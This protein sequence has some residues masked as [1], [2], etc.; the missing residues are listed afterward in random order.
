MMNL[1]ALLLGVSF[2]ATLSLSPMTAANEESPLGFADN[3]TQA[4][5]SVPRTLGLTLDRYYSPAVGS[6]LVLSLLHSVQTL[7]DRWLSANQNDTSLQPVLSRIG[8]FAIEGLLWNTATTAQHEI[9]GHGFRAREFHIPAH[10][11]VNIGGGGRIRFPAANYHQL[12]SHEKAAFNAGGMEGNSRLAKNLRDQWLNH[13]HMD[14]REAHVYLN[15]SLDQTLY[16][17]DTFKKDKNAIANGHDVANYIA[18]VNT[19]YGT[20]VLTKDKLKHRA[21]LDLLD[22]YLFYSLYSVGHYLH[23]GTQSFEYPMISLGNYQYLPA[24]RVIPAPYGIEYQ[25]MNFVKGPDYD[26]QAGLRA[27]KTGTLSSHALDLEINRLF[28]SAL[29]F[30]DL[31]TSLWRQPK[32]FTASAATT[33]EHMGA[34]LSMVARYRMTQSV[35]LSGQAGYKTTGYMPGEILKHSPI[36]RL[37][38][39]AFL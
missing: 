27:G 38:F 22:P 9:F 2:F 16:M 25:W 32:L 21:L 34:A 14:M 36:L 10:Y 13:S 12:S 39:K 6:E 18:E 28:S 23:D 37:G 20:T 11:R 8:Q 1:R 30:V 29:L 17:R 5:I 31:K 15:A 26:I 3:A 19:W 35:E 33:K 4:E 24:L 7:E